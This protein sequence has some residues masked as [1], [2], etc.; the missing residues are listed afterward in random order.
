MSAQHK[1]AGTGVAIITPFKKD[2]SIDFEGLEKQ[3]EHLIAN[4]I[5]YLV[6]LGTTGESV[7]QTEKEKAELVKFILEKVNQRLPIVL[8]IGGNNT[9]AV[10]DKIKNTDLSKI[11][12]ILSVAPYYNKPTQEGLYQHFK[13]IANAS[14]V[15]IILY[16]VP[17]RTGSNINAETTVR[18]AHDFKNIVAV[19]EASGDFSQAMSIIKNKPK[20][21]IVVSG[22]DALTLPLMS[23]GISGVISVVAN[24]FPKEFSSMVQLA[25]KNNFK[26]A[27]IIHYQLLNLINTLFVE[28]NPGGIK[29]SLEILGIIE[30]NLRLPLVPV[31]DETYNKLDKLIQEI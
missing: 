23:V 31:S 18:L 22:E 5:N 8:G 25:L 12:A 24:A 30:N 14:P 17:G 21:F 3:I 1:F 28:G 9:K 16:N 7:T 6:V 29:A 26:E 20:D 2:L 27:E 11:D 15:D 10:V 13:A 19:K 4:G